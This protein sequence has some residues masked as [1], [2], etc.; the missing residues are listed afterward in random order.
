MNQTRCDNPG[1]ILSTETFNTFQVDI[2]G[3]LHQC[4]EFPCIFTCVEPNS[5]YSFAIPIKSTQD[6]EICRC[7]ELIRFANNGFPRIILAD[8]ALFTEHALSTKVL[9][10]E[11][12]KIPHGLPYITRGQSAIERYNNTLMRSLIKM[13]T[14]SSQPLQNIVTPTAMHFNLT[15]NPILGNRTPC[16]MQFRQPQSTFV[17]LFT[18]IPQER[19]PE[20]AAT[21]R[22]RQINFMRLKTDHIQLS[23]D[24]FMKRKKS[25]NP[26]GQYDLL[27]VGDL[28][29]QKQTSFLR[30]AAIKTQFKLSINIYEII[31]RVATNAFRIRNIKSNQELICA[32]DHLIQLRYPHEEAIKLLNNLE[33]CA[34]DQDH[35][36]VIHTCSHGPIRPSSETLPQ[37]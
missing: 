19:M 12:V 14:T 35:I 1:M 29:L 5:K 36:N 3:P 20:Q 18:E 11:G 21:I 4:R 37:L 25:E 32:G 8:S 33:Q 28:C 16:G 26:L 7:L 23:V 34:R 17:Q 15:P 6:Q 22:D 27:Q 9:K 10:A 30:H 13:Q 31:E 24:R 2:I